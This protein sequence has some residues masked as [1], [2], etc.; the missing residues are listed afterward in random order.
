LTDS[1]QPNLISPLSDL[2]VGESQKRE[3]RALRDVAKIR[4][5]R[6]PCPLFLPLYLAPQVGPR[7]WGFPLKAGGS[8]YG[9]HV[10]SQLPVLA[11]EGPH[12]RSYPVG[13]SSR[14]WTVPPQEAWHRCQE[15]VTMNVSEILKE[16]S[17]WQLGVKP[18]ASVVCLGPSPLLLMAD[19]PGN[20][21]LVH[22]L[23][24]QTEKVK[25]AIICPP[26]P[27]TKSFPV[28]QP[29]RLS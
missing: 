5:T 19:I 27:S 18:S 24:R 14:G 7:S 23:Y 8:A 26:C 28:Y 1:A 13:S 16:S 10:H 20:P 9:C 12:V 22:N 29:D 2:G 17:S 21:L 4:V 3:G 11:V 15:L 6:S 25:A